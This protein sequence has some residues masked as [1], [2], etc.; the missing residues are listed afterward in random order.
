MRGSLEEA[1]LDGCNGDKSTS[2]ESEETETAVNRDERD[3]SEK[4]FVDH[5]RDAYPG[6]GQDGAR[7]HGLCQESAGVPVDYWC[8]TLSDLLFLREAVK[9]AVIRGTIRPSDKDEFDPTDDVIGPNMYTVCSQY[10]APLTKEA[11]AMSWALL[12]NPRGLRCDLFVTHAWIE[13]IYEFIDKVVA[14]WPVGMQA[15]YVCMLSNPQCLDIAELIKTPADS[16]FAICLESASHMLVIPNQSAS[17]YCRLWCV[18]EAWLA[19]TRRKI[20]VTAVAPVDRAVIRA[21]MIAMVPFLLGLVLGFHAAHCD[22][23]VASAKGNLT[24][25]LALIILTRPLSIT[26]CGC[27]KSG[28]CEAL[29]AHYPLLLGVNIIGVAVSGIQTGMDLKQWTVGCYAISDDLAFAVWGFRWCTWLLAVFFFASEAD[30]IRLMRLNVEAAELRREFS[31]AGEAKCSSD[32]DRE[33][34]LREIHQQ[35]DDVDMSVSVLMVSGMSTPTLREAASKGVNVTNAGFVCFTHI[36]LCVGF[37][38]LLQILFFSTLADEPGL[39]VVIW[40][41]LNSATLLVYLKIFTKRR[42]RDEQAYIV[43]VSAKILLIGFILLFLSMSP[44]EDPR[45]VSGFL[46]HFL[47]F[48]VVASILSLLGAVGTARIPLVGPIVAGLLGPASTCRAFRPLSQSA[49]LE[50]PSAKVVVL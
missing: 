45:A 5:D 6:W 33:H 7:L 24:L 36:V 11:G 28:C 2:P 12:R 17:I 21:V 35:L 43:S 1:R 14:S 10:I 15:C 42:P 20:I 29:L 22:L 41:G 18:Y 37:V 34:I 27:I 40:V 26:R 4:C 49:T 31:S 3:M 47:F 46:F 50:V 48:P 16:P 32:L 9:D 25:V 38:V 30:R 44:E 39:D 13:G 8:V 19:C 23:G